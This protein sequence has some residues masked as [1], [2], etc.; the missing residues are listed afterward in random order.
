MH[1]STKN[2]QLPYS[3][4]AH[5]PPSSHLSFILVVILFIPIIVNVVLLALHYTPHEP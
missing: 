3:Q 2:I 1:A 4:L 5:N